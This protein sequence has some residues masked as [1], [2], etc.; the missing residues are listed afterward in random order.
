MTTSSLLRFI[1]GDIASNEKYGIVM[2]KWRNLFNITQ[3]RIAKEMNVKQSVI[4]DYENNR[5]ASPGINII[6]SYVLALI[7]IAKKEH[8]REYNELLKSLNIDEERASLYRGEFKTELNN[9]RIM[10]LFNATQVIAPKEEYKFKEFVFFSKNISSIVTNQPSYKLLKELKSNT[11]RLFIFSNVKSGQIPL[12]TI[13]LL[14]KINH[15]DLPKLILFQS[16][17]FKISNLAKRIA[18][19]NNISIMI[20]KMNNEDIL[21]LLRMNSEEINSSG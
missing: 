15:T 18:K 7:K 5:R 1:A 12:I 17:K 9:K 21:E 8:P 16:N 6:R 14:S 11:N 10:K 20:T 4:S 2:K 13:T 3:S 19:S